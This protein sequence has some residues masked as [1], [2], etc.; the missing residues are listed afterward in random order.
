VLLLSTI[1]R[2]CDLNCRGSNEPGSVQNWTAV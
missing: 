2:L 1:E